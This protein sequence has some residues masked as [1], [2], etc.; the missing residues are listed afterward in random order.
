MSGLKNDFELIEKIKNEGCEQSLLKLC[1]K[2]GGVCLRVIQKYSI[3]IKNK[4]I[5]IQ[6][7]Y[8]DKNYIIYKAALSF[9]PKKNMKVSSWIGAYT[10]YYCLTMI[11]KSE[12]LIP[13]E[14]SWSSKQITPPNNHTVDFIF[15][16]LSSL[17]DRRIYKIFELRY[18]SEAKKL[19]WSKIGKTMELSNQTVINLHKRGLNLLKRKISSKEIFDNV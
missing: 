6:D 8:N 12:N 9:K 2:H 1:L 13:L 3:A 19:S 11:T 5:D 18:F 17:K 15:N 10:R 4:G 16:I 7:V 14:E